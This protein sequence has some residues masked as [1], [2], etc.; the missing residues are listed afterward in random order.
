M[1]GKLGLGRTFLTTDHVS[2]KVIANAA[3]GGGD[4]EPLA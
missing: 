1:G 3:R 2:W 4:E